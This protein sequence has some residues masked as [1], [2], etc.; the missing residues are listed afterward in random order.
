VL[1]QLDLGHD[2][3]AMVHEIRE[4]AEF[5]ARKL[6]GQ[7]VERDLR[8]PRIERDPSRPKFG[9]RLA[10]RSP[11]ERP[12]SC[13]Q[14]FHLERLRDVVIRAGID[15]LDLLVPT[16]ARGQHEHGRRQTAVAPLPQQREAVDLRQ[17]EIED[18]GVVP[19]GAA[20]HV[21]ALAVG[22][23]VHGISRVAQRASDPLR[24]PGLV[25]D[26]ENAHAGTVRY[27]AST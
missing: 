21:G 6:H 11:D 7:T 18:D 3:P 24:Q 1:G 26:D 20:E 5:V 14:F 4:H 16:A 9:C 23:A 12:Q 2:A 22:R 13:E 19:F 17:A 25:L 15:P 27:S 10:A 8:E